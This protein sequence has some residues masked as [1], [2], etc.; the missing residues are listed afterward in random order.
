MRKKH[1]EIFTYLM[2][3]SYNYYR[4]DYLINHSGGLKMRKY[5]IACT[6]NQ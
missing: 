3:C 5:L 4:Q 1:A 2:I 6:L